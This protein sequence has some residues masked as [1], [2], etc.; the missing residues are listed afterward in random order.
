MAQRKPA[1]SSHS[2]SGNCQRSY[3]SNDKNRDLHPPSASSSQGWLLYL[4]LRTA[5]VEVTG[6]GTHVT[7][8]R[9][10]HG[11]VNNHWPGGRVRNNKKEDGNMSNH[12]LGEY[13][14]NSQNNVYRPPPLG[15][16]GRQWDIHVGS[17]FLDRYDGRSKNYQQWRRNDDFRIQDSYDGRLSSHHRDQQNG[18]GIRYGRSH[19]NHTGRGSNNYYH[20]LVQSVRITSTSGQSML[21]YPTIYDPST[22]TSNARSSDDLNLPQRDNKKDSKFQKE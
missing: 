7:T 13:V 15:N 22:F 10:N 8:C 18:E 2:W 9:K 6:R 17:W 4:C 5:S 21:D 14:G 20:P 12:C 19:D 1:P 11:N 3:T 16:R